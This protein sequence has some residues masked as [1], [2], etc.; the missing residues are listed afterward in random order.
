MIGTNAGQGL[1]LALRLPIAKRGRRFRFL[2]LKATDSVLCWCGVNNDHHSDGAGAQLSLDCQMRIRPRER[3][4]MKEVAL[5]WR[6]MVR[7]LTQPEGQTLRTENRAFRCL[8]VVETKCAH[9]TSES[10]LREKISH[11]HSSLLCRFLYGRC[12]VCSK[13]PRSERRRQRKIRSPDSSPG[14]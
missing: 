14:D 6:Q 2:D 12:R 9:L 4:F 10:C 5:R 11:A 7:A 13:R 3:A 8:R 1:R